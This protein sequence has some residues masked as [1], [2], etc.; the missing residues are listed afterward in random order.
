MYKA[1]TYVVEKDGKTYLCHTYQFTMRNK[2][3]VELIET[4]EKEVG[5]G[6]N[7]QKAINDAIDK[8]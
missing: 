5:S 1:E 2:A 7:Y 3:I 4:G 8:F 6:E